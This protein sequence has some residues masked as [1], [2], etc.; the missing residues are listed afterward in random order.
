LQ[1]AQAQDAKHCD[2]DCEEYDILDDV[3]GSE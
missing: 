3:F 2:Y 1:I